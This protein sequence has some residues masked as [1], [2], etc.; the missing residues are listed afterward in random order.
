M[1]GGRKAS[2]DSRRRQWGRVIAMAVAIALLIVCGI[3]VGLWR[4]SRRLP[5]VP[6]DEV[7]AA[8]VVAVIPLSYEYEYRTTDDRGYLSFIYDDGS[9][10]LVENAGMDAKTEMSVDWDEQGIFFTDVENDYRLTVNGAGGF[11][12]QVVTSPKGDV[13]N[14]VL[15]LSGGAH[16]VIVDGG[17]DSD[18]YTSGVYRYKYTV[19]YNDGSS[20]LTRDV[21]RDESSSDHPLLYS[22]CGDDVYMVADDERNGTGTAVLTQLLHGNEVVDETVVR[23]DNPLETTG[24]AQSPAPCEANVVYSLTMQSYYDGK[25]APQAN[26]SDSNKGDMTDV[27]SPKSADSAW[28]A[29]LPWIASQGDGLH[30]VTW[31]WRNGGATWDSDPASLIRPC[32]EEYGHYGYA[33]LDMWDVTTGDRTVIPLLNEDGSL[34]DPCPATVEAASY[35]G[36]SV[37]DGALTWMSG[38]NSLM[39]TDIGT[40]VTR[41]LNSTL[42]YGGAWNAHD[43]Y[44]WVSGGR[45]F[46]MS[47]PLGDVEGECLMTVFDASDGSV[48]HTVEV[49]GLAGRLNLHMMA[50]G[51]AVN[52]QYDWSRMA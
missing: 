10:A 31:Q 33:S 8:R 11:D 23:T 43:M 2:R 28:N 44:A 30:F 46:D 39:V 25:S 12:A 14:A 22:A 16:A 27:Q 38:S 5:V 15:P 34:F 32:G 9:Y 20:S 40:G 45:V 35:L 29:A 37:R 18:D 17:F 1:S 48:L 21:V 52:P 6:W 51:F 50:Q 24:A 41:T 19:V 3:G 26:D 7:D 36:A 42:G 4:L 49:R 47:C 13:L